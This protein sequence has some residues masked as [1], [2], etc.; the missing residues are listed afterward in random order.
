[1][2]FQYK[3][4]LEGASSGTVGYSPDLH[5]VVQDD[6]LEGVEIEVNSE[7]EVGARAIDER[8]CSQ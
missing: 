8:E 3:E 1:V 4:G 7:G 5:L 6:E 2:L